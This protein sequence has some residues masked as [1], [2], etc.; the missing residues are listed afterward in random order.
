MQI[1]LKTIQIEPKRKT[2]DNLVRRF[3]D[4]PASRYQEASYDIQA[5]E[6]LHYRPTWAPGQELYDTQSS[7]VK[8]ADWDAFKDP[9]Q[10]FYSTYTLTRARQQEAV[11]GAFA[12]VESRGLHHSVPADVLG[13]ALA[14][15]VPLRHAAWTSNQNNV[16]I[17]GYGVGTTFTQP[18]LYQ[19]MD[20]LA[21][22]QYVSRAG[23]LFGGSEALSGGREAWIGADAWQPL[24]R[25]AED[26]M[27]VR[28]PVELFLAQ[29]FAIDGLLYPV[30][31]ET[32]IDGVLSARGASAISMVTQFQVDWYA[33]TAKWVDSVLKIAATESEGNAAAL[34]EWFASWSAR[35][36]AALLPVVEPVLGEGADAAIAEAQDRL[37]KRAAKAGLAL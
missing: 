1:D 36:A 28:D 16:L 11:E 12:F 14:V 19:G 31:Y 8:M 9:R 34:A 13:A 20:A 30:V 5:K 29:N 35:A 27:V 32:L 23:L 15:L 25:L 4:K 2:F 37:R 7:R 10:Y 33:E 6:N 22:A 24:R 18:C 3:G 21:I 26:T 17:A